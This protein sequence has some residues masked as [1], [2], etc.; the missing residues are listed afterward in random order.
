MRKC[1]SYSGFIQPIKPKLV[2]S[3]KMLSEKTNEMNTE[4]VPDLSS[5]NV[6]AMND[7]LFK[8]G[9][10]FEEDNNIETGLFYKSAIKYIKPNKSCSEFDTIRK[11]DQ[12]IDRSISSTNTQE[13]M[14]VDIVDKPKSAFEESSEDF[15]ESHKFEEW[16][17]SNS[18]FSEPSHDS[19]VDHFYASNAN[20]TTFTK[21]VNN[22]FENP[23]G[24]MTNLQRVAILVFTCFET[25]RTV[26]SSFLTVFV[27]QNCGG[28]SC[29]IIE[30]IIPKDDLE[31]VAISINTFMAFYFC[32]LFIIES[33]REKIVKKY[34]IADKSFS[35]HKD[36][37]VK[38]LS[39][40]KKP[41][42]Q[43]IFK[44]NAV[45][46][47]V[48][49]IL[50]V[51]FFINASISCVVIRKNYLNNTTATV[52]ITNMFFTINRIHKSLKITSSGEY[53]IYST[54]RTENLI[55]N[56]YRGELT[57]DR[58]P[59]ISFPHVYEY[60]KRHTSL[61]QQDRSFIMNQT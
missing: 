37:L 53:N 11:N 48:T 52:F 5:Y 9:Q 34:L 57:H 12:T 32:V 44:L 38:M 41:E 54:Y 47:I 43:E 24:R 40:M 17:V 27:P 26:I 1:N 2:V 16:K 58:P 10:E 46:R 22:L 14:D 42:R 59:G 39:D 15:E 21:F 31:V 4:Y 6:N 7:F 35:T 61:P 50:L 19:F 18:R 33:I 60:I 29:T 45:Y 55:Y 3:S 36:Y 49:H 30:N 8:I 56:R 51:T 28:Y 23:E 25:Y 13:R 20:S